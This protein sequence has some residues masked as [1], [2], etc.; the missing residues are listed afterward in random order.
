MIF[1][2]PTITSQ[3]IAN[4]LFQD[5]IPELYE[6]KSVIEH[7]PWHN[8]QS[9][10]DHTVAVVA[11]LEKIFLFD[12]LYANSSTAIRTYVS[13]QTNGYPL[14]GISLLGGLFHDIAK[15]TTIVIDPLTGQTQCPNHDHI[16]SA[17]TPKILLRM[18]IKQ[19]VRRDVQEIV[20][21]HGEILEVV[22]RVLMNNDPEKEFSLLRCTHPYMYLLLI[23]QGYA[24]TM[25]SSLSVLNPKEYKKREIIYRE[26]INRFA[27]LLDRS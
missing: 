22:N 23:I 6:L 19:Q 2:L 27:V 15:G 9:V 16:G 4:G 21:R 13:R 26:A 17:L 7:N 25:G 11:S 18:H 12:F 5:I 10:F 24:D 3:N 20:K 1:T 14:T 8:N